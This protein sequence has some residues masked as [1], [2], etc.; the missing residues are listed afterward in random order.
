MKKVF[1]LTLIIASLCSLVSA[2]V[3]SLYDPSYVYTKEDNGNLKWLDTVSAGVDFDSIRGTYVPD[4]INKNANTKKLE[5][6]KVDYKG[7]EAYILK[8]GLIETKDNLAVIIKPAVVYTWNNRASFENI[9]LETGTVIICSKKEADSKSGLQKISFFDDKVFWKIRDAYINPEAVSTYSDDYEAVKLA[10]LALTKDAKKEMEII[11]KLLST[12]ERRAQSP[13]IGQYVEEIDAKIS[14]KEIV[15]VA[16]EDFSCSGRISSDGA[17][18]N[19]RKSPS[20]S[21]SVVGQLEDE[22]FIYASKKTVTS[23]TIGGDSNYWFYISCES[24]GLEGW[25]FG[26]SARWERD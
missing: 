25:I 13:E 12:A 20:T 10:K 9:L 1:I 19:V 17:R 11:T 16:I 24:N 26:A 5:Y 21:A 15:K 23:E 6:A 18:V 14:G 7:K 3:Y 22:E 4:T 8:S 2:E